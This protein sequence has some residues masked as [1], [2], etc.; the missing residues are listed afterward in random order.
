MRICLNQLTGL[1]WLC[2]SLNASASVVYVDLHSPNPMPPYTN[3]TT[4]ATNIQDAVDVSAPGD[5]IWVND[6]VYQSGGRVVYGSLTNRL[7]ISKA[8]TVESV[9]GPAM[10][11][12]QGN[13][14]LGDTA[15]R[16]VYMTNDAILVGFTI[17]HG[18]TRTNGDT[19]LELCGGGVY[20]ESSSAVLSNCALTANVSQNAGGGIYQGTLNDSSLV[21]NLAGSFIYYGSGGGAYSSVLNR[22]LV[23]GN[24]AGVFGGGAHLCTLNKCTITAN[25]TV[26]GGGVAFCGLNSCVVANNSGN[27]DGGGAYSSSLTN[28]LV[29]S[30]TVSCSYCGFLGGTG[31]G[32]SSCSLQNCTV[33]GNHA[34]VNAGGIDAKSQAT[35]CIL[36]YNTVWPGADANYSAAAGLSYCCT[37]PSPSGTGSITNDPIFVSMASGDFHLQATSPCVNAG[38]NLHA[39]GDTDLDGN[40]RLIGG[41]IDLGAYEYQTPIPLTL[42]LLASDTNVAT[43]FA[44]SFQALVQG[45]TPTVAAWDFGDS[46]TTTG[47]LFASHVWTSAGDYPLTLLLSNDF[48]PGGISVTVM[49]HAVSQPVNYVS[50]AGTNPV[51]P[52]SSWDTAATNIQDAVDVSFSG[53]LILVTNGV[54]L[55]GGRMVSG[56]MTNRVAVNRPVTLRSVNGP[57][58]TV[59][60]GHQVPGSAYG[61]SAVRCAYLANNATLIGFTLTNGGTRGSGKPDTETSGGGIWCDSSS[62]LR[63]SNCIAAGNV[64][65]YQGGGV[66]QGTMV[67]SILSGNAV[68]SGSSDGYG[69]GGAAY[70]SCLL[71]SVIVGNS[72]KAFYGYGGAIYNGNVTN[73]VIC[74]NSCSS[75]YGYGGGTCTGIVANCTIAGN[76]CPGKHGLGGG[77]YKGTLIN[78]TITGNYAAYMGGGAYSA[79]Q[80]NCINTFNICSNADFS[81]NYIGGS[82]SYCCTM[83]L[84]SGT[85][86][87]SANPL[88]ANNRS[89]F[90]LQPRSP[91]INAGNNAYV[92]SGTDL[93]GN[94]RI[95]GGT[96]DIGAY[97]FPNPYS[98]ISYAWLQQYGLPTD[99]TAD[100][101]DSDNDGMSN[102][103]EW[104]AGTDPTNPSSLLKMLAP[105]T[106]ISGTT[107][108]WQ[109]VNGKTYLLQRSTNLA[110]QPTFSSIQSN[111]A[112]QA[113]AT[114]FTDTTATNSGPYFYRVGVQ[115]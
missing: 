33:V 57:G 14:V 52:Y 65:T 40:P 79:I 110:L 54:Y 30:N 96:V 104:T 50:A 85:G 45:G 73:C 20:C 94:P 109:S 51:A 75:Y 99:G 77:G 10:T 4:A 22:C 2:V 63:I 28:C 72:N 113:G 76:A 82:F 81:S 64:A 98:V 69:Y 60:E 37:T 13:P 6:G 78:S 47:T 114:S 26:N 93:D 48:T 42:V 23:S 7:A 97:E 84:P 106:S 88:L 62:G 24:Q 21:N 102:W 87:I 70:Q 67:N 89:D 19:V 115:Q 83:P 74:S 11:I 39:S 112:G 34:V 55:H 18:A 100:S 17:T 25:G 43:G 91:C 32:A 90:H 71:N 5:R 38:N 29:V 44:L 66:Y 49:V 53:A 86:N 3:W 61:D 31:G 105:S 59:I 111:I 12:I 58:V 68:L 35:N 103:Q 95:E 80:L 1:T 46:S 92:S 27:G 36:F 101:I 8:V 15:V 41:M 16:C 9:N 56:A 108:N 107:I